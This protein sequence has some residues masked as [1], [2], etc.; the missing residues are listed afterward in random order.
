MTN[1]LFSEFIQQQNVIPK[2]DTVD[3]EA[4]LDEWKKYLHTF[5]KQVEGYLQ[6]Y[7]A[8]G[9]IKL[10]R[11]NIDIH[12][13]NIGTYEVDTLNITVGNQT[14][15]L[16]PIGTNLIGA[17]GRIDMVGSNGTVI[18]ILVP[19]DAN[20]P[21]ISVQIRS[22]N[23][24]QKTQQQTT[25]TWT[26]KISTPPPRISYLELEEESFQAALMEVVNG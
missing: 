20:N 22:Q 24:P 16:T 25:S 7:I 6:P 15:T 5:H 12:E 13:E 3:W 11:E 18:F 2:K 21:K 19:K 17:K 4:E 14:I 10:E 1:Q 9:Q 23:E 8:S 26:W